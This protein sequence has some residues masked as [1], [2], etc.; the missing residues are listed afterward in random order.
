[1]SFGTRVYYI[2]MTILAVPALAS[3]GG[4][5]SKSQLADLTVNPERPIVITADATLSGDKKITGPWFQFTMNMTNGSTEPITIVALELEV[6]A[7]DD[8]GVIS[9]RPVAFSPG[10]FD[11]N[12]TETINCKYA[13][14][15][16]WQPG[17]TKAMTLESSSDAC[18]GIPMFIVGSNAK[19][20]DG[21]NFR[22]RVKVK[23]AGWFGTFDKATDRF[24]KSIVF[25]TQ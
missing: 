15:G 3:C 20:A 16:T 21:K 11:F 12:L 7:P 14:F 25:T 22:Y 1:M 13:S 19:G 5:K 6:S 9:S 8:T 17:Q 10:E 18:K 23:P 24:E 2:L 4:K